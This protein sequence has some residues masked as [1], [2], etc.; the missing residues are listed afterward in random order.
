MTGCDPKYLF[1]KF[2]KHI[3]ISEHTTYNSQKLNIAL[4]KPASMSNDTPN[5][6]VT[7]WNELDLFLKCPDFQQSL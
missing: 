5:R 4:F 7:L 1:T 6:I 2:V 3:E